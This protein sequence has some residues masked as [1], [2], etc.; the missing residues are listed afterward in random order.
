[1]VFA[2]CGL[3][4]VSVV[5]Y[6][7]NLGSGLTSHSP[8][9]PA[10]LWLVVA[11]QMEMDELLQHLREREVALHQPGVRADVNRL[12]ELLHESFA[13]IGRSGRSYSR[14]DIL[15]ELPLENTSRVTRFGSSGSRA[16]TR[17]INLPV[18]R[19]ESAD[20]D[21]GWRSKL[22]GVIT[23]SGLRTERSI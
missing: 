22:L 16:S 15:E 23:T 20:V 5:V 19:S 14:A 9:M 6:L 7:T 10:A 2:R 1:M 17:G 8:G 4:W 12:E 18:L 13:E 11:R 3:R 21:S